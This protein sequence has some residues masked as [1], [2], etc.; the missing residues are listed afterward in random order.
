MEWCDGD[1]NGFPVQLALLTRAQWQAAASIPRSL[2]DSR[3][4]LELHLAEYRQQTGGLINKLSV[5]GANQTNE[6]KGIF[7]AHAATVNQASGSIRDQVQ[8][9]AVVA[10]QIKKFLDDGVST[11]DRA[12]T[13]MEAGSEKFQKACEELH[14]R[15]TWR[16][17]R[18][19]WLTLLGLIS[20]GIVIGVIVGLIIA[21][22]YR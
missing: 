16:E 11:W 15:I 8:E 13:G 19:D 6:L 17:L 12:K 10:Q 4:W 22:K 1:E 3:K 5:V 9:A 20:I 21:F 14:D 7:I 2:T 18:R